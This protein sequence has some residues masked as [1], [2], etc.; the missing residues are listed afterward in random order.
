[1]LSNLL[2]RLV[3]PALLV[4]FFTLAASAG[5]VTDA[6]GRPLTVAQTFSITR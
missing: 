3:A 4:A 5:L 2:P 6:A 1:M